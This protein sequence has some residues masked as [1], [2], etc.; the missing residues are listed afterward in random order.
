[1]KP[2]IAALLLLIGCEHDLSPEVSAEAHWLLDSTERQRVA[3]L[4]R[5][6]RGF[7]MAM[8]EVGYRYNQLHGATQERNWEYAEYQ[9]GKLE[10]AIALGLERRPARAA[11]AAMI[12]AP[13]AAFRTAL[14]G[15][16]PHAVD[17]AFAELTATCNRCHSAE[18]VSFIRIESPGAPGNTFV[19]PAFP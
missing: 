16:S 11:S 6:L 13:I 17:A 2:W 8:V 7:D 4:S 9:L 5:H 15:R 12:N 3:Q 19:G 1:M 14:E 18:G 10:L